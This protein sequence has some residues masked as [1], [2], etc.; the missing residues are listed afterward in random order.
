VSRALAV[1]VALSLVGAGCSHRPDDGTAPAS[2]EPLPALVIRDDS[3][4]LLLTWLDPR[5]VGHTEVHPA[6][7]P[8]AGRGLVRV[9]VADREDGTHDRFYVVDLTKP[10]ADGGYPARTMTRG[11]WESE[12]ARRRGDDGTVPPPE[13]QREPSK[14]SSGDAKPPHGSAAVHVVIYGAS[15]CQPCHQAAAW[16][17]SHGVAYVLK[18]I[19]AD[20]GAEADMRS[21]LASANRRGGSIPVIDVEGQVL[22]GFNESELARAVDKA[23]RG[24]TL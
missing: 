23:S 3:P 24:T 19:E 17:K 7:V 16:L 2:A 14:T 12:I 15:W 13:A 6:D 4:N 9:V 1:A 18:D 20:P 22:V 5:G 21:A 8:P 11:A 10:R